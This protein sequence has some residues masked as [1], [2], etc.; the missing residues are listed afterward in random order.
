MA[1][2]IQPLQDGFICLSICFCLPACLSVWLSKI[3]SYYLFSPGYPWTWCIA[4]VS[5]EFVLLLPLLPECSDYRSYQLQNILVR[6]SQ[7]GISAAWVGEVPRTAR[8]GEE[9][10]RNADSLPHLHL[11]EA[12][13]FWAVLMHT[14]FQECSKIR[15]KG[16]L[17]K[18]SCLVDC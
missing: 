7:R 15:S 18:L 10:V 5:H 8:V 17:A 12:E 2:S 16:S 6:A 11:P 14:E 3:R 1:I 4:Q 13:A 9:S